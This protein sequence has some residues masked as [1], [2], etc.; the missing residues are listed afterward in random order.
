M[1]H[2]NPHRA[3]SCS[4]GGSPLSTLHT[5]F[6]GWGAAEVRASTPWSRAHAS[7]ERQQHRLAA[8]AFATM[9]AS[10]KAKAAYH[11]GDL[12]RALIQTTLEI[13]AEKGPDAF[14]LREAARRIGVNHRAVYRHFPDRIALLAAVALEGY[15]HL[16]DAYTQAL[17][18]LHG[19]S[20]HARLLAIAQRYVEFAMREPARY[21]LMTGPRLNED[22]RFPELEAAL[23]RDFAIVSDE[24]SAG[25][26]RREL[27]PVDIKEAGISLL[28][29]I[30]G[31]SSLIVMRRIRVRRSLLPAFTERVI[32]P[33]LRGFAAR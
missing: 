28:A 3:R 13:L 7:L 16:G 27:A 17:A 32:G 9:P 21:R 14:T 12:R 11:H 2:L 8:T 24:I 1:H 6:A 23:A 26:E 25:I 29:A 18:E 4:E 31:L 33:T 30:H 19:A 10:S 5:E 15:L 22:G 20:T